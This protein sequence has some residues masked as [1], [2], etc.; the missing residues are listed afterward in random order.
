ML[1]IIIGRFQPQTF[2]VIMF[3]IYII[4]IINGRFQPQIFELKLE[5]G[6]V[7]FPLQFIK[8]LNYSG[9]G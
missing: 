4:Y 2:L 7:F 1:Y 8:I 5:I 9:H 6:M 3:I